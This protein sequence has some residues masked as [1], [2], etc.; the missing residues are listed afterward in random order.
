M[1]TLHGIHLHRGQQPAL[2]GIDF[3]LSAGEVVGILGGNGAGKSTLLA[4]LAGELNPEQG[5]AQLDG[6]PLAGFGPQTL[7]RRRALLPQT[8]G[9]P[10]ELTVEEIV[11]MG[12]YPWPE[13]TPA[14]AAT[15][16]RQALSDADASALRHRAYPTLSGGEVLRVQFAR[17]LVQIRGG[18]QATPRYLLLD[19]P[20]AHLDPKHQHQLLATAQR[21]SREAQVGVAVVL[22]DI[23]LAARWCD[24]L[25]LLKQGRLVAQGTVAEILTRDTL[26]A[27]FDC[28]ALLLPHPQE[29]GRVLALL[30]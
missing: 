20:T 4:V 26:E 22:H 3:T 5:S 7:A 16:V 14:D 6:K 23:N 30:G 25:A 21:L 13:L 10:F 12:I 27:T 9:F 18:D 1:L 15:L 29:P 19:E 28:P 8:Q 2:A 11:G 17:M 24:R